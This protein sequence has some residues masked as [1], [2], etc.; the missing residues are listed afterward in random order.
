MS[1]M[2][3]WKQ[4]THLIG[5]LLIG[6]WRAADSA[7]ERPPDSHSSAQ[8]R[9]MLNKFVDPPLAEV[10]GVGVFLFKQCIYLWPDD[11]VCWRKSFLSKAINLDDNGILLGFREAFLVAVGLFGRS[12]EASDSA[13]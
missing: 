3:P 4:T 12:G 8:L 1:E 9:L 2:P 7:L 6:L 11:L 5:H 10:L 13:A